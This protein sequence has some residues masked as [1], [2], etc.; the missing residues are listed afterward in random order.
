VVSGLVAC[1][2]EP[3]AAADGVVAAS[4]EHDRFY[5]VVVT[6]CC[7]A[8]LVAAAAQDSAEGMAAALV[9]AGQV[10]PLELSL[11]VQPST[12]PATLV[13]V[14]Q[15]EVRTPPGCQAAAAAFRHGVLLSKWQHS[16]CPPAGWSL[17]VMSVCLSRGAV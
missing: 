10:Q 12:L 13:V 4:Q 9:A 8:E 5:P 7:S 1:P 15:G 14:Y 17:L 2:G 3:A 6:P 16:A 11:S